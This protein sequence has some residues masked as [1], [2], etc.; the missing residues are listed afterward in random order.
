M[1][2]EW[3]NCLLAIAAIAL[4]VN[5]VSKLTLGQHLDVLTL[6]Q[7]HSV[8]EV[9]DHYWLTGGRL[10]RYQALLTETLDIILWV[11]QTLNPATLLPVAESGDSL[12]HCINTIEQ[13]YSSRS[14]LLDESLDSPE[15]KWFTDGSSFIEM[16]TWKVGHAIA[17]LDQVTEAKAPPTQTSAQ[18]WN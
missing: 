3:P 16:G 2:L 6:Y 15:V 14:D 17:S 1:A 10:T 5:E 12:H 8:L 9:K 13:A 4:L 7:V 18:M 11:C